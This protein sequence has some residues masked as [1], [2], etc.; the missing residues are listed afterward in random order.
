[1]DGI[2]VQY[3]QPMVQFFHLTVIKLYFSTV[4]MTAIKT[5]C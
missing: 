4:L 1:M 2:M 3:A 5:K